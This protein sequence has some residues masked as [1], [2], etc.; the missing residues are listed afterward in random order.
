MR[1]RFNTQNPLAVS[2][3]N[4]LRWVQPPAQDVHRST[5]GAPPGHPHLASLPRWIGT[6]RPLRPRTAQIKYSRSVCASLPPL[7]MTV[8]TALRGISKDE[9]SN[10]HLKANVKPTHLLFTNYI[11]VF[12]LFTIVYV[13]K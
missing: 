1:N 13:S 7:D 3:F 6:G 2:A 4:E 8:A 10:V 9:D 5:S 11:Y 12:P